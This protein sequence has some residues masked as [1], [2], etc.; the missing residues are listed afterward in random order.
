M[1]KE[2]LKG[3]Q[4]RVGVMIKWIPVSPNQITISSILLAILSVYLMF[5]GRY[6][7]GVLVFLLAGLM[8]GLDGALARAR[9]ES[10]SW[11]GF[12]D[13]VSD[14]IVEGLFL[15]SLMFLPLPT[16]FGV[17]HEVWL[18]LLIF[19]GTCLPSYVRAYADHK[20]V[21]SSED[22]NRMGGLFERTER[23]IFIVIGVLLG[24]FLGWEVTMYFIVVSVILSVI[25][26]LQRVH[27][28]FKTRMV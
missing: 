7:W 9:G 27:Y 16:L 23:I 3:I 17:R 19:F 24:L 25:T 12:L 2:R 1:L 14:R 21:I 4:K 20:H 13:G 26:L 28:V 10:T 11:G 8:D 22:A 6:V 15:I 18:S 5:S